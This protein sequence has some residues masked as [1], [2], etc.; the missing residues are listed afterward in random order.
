MVI[1]EF[2]QGV[3]NK[4]C[5]AEAREVRLREG[6]GGEGIKNKIKTSGS[7]FSAKWEMSGGA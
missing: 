5:E 3:A 6:R 2:E 1:R 4:Q 7:E